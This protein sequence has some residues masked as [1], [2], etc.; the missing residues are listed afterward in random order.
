[1]ACQCSSPGIREIKGEMVAMNDDRMFSVSEVAQFLG[2]TQ[3]AVRQRIL[4]GKLAA[5][6]IRVKGIAREYRIGAKAVQEHYALTDSDMNRLGRKAVRYRVGFM[7]WGTGLPFPHYRDEHST[8]DK[9][10]A[11]AKRVLTILPRFREENAELEHLLPVTFPEEPDKAI[12][13]PNPFDFVKFGIE[14]DHPAVEVI[15]GP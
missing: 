12:V 8:Y 3:Q 2:V 7:G 14:V 5:S 9:A 1:M 6:K 13:Y 10:V 4:E 11:E 15:E